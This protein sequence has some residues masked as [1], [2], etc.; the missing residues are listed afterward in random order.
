MQQ[1]NDEAVGDWKFARSETMELLD[2]LSDEDLAFVPE[3]E[4]WQ[5]LYYQFACMA[6]TQLVYAQALKTGSMDFAAFGD[7]SLPSKFEQNTGEALRKLFAKSS[8]A[9]ADAIADSAPN[10]QWPGHRASVSGHIYRLISHERLHHGQLISYFT[11]A[12]IDL[13]PKFK[14]NWAL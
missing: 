14:A 5:P 4:K 11:L 12:G 2:A 6:R 8:A 13:P 10:V 9:W 7:P 1:T 3:G